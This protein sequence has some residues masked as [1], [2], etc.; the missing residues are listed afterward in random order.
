MNFERV[1]GP[2]TLTEGPAWDGD[3][4]LF[5][6]IQNDRILRYD[7]AT[8]RIDVFRTGTEGGNGLMFDAEGR[9]YGCQQWSRRIVR[10]EPDG[11][12]TVIVDRLDGRRLNSPNDL[13]IDSRGRIWFSDPRYRA[14]MAPMELDHHS[15]LRATPGADGSWTLERVTFDTT[16]PNGLLVSADDRWLYVAESPPAPSG[17]RELRAYP[18]ADDGTVGN[19]EVLHTFGPHR[20]IDGMCLDVEGNI[21]A[22]AGWEQSGPGG[23]I[24]VFSPRGRVLS[25]HPMPEP[26]K[27]PTNCKF[28]GPELRTLYVTDIDGYLHRAETDHV[29]WH[30]W[31]P[32]P[33]AT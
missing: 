12:T 16:R 11:S 31:P 32:R 25:T 23:M 20:G 9:L 4:L 28:G 13:A 5:S 27:R 18:I 14:E 15:V 8:G 1:A 2:Y 21:V 30:R 7:P 6:D 26:V 22:T 19:H 24:Y 29:G 3:G 33:S 17:Q 10:Y